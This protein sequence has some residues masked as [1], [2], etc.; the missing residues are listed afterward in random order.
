[1]KFYTELGVEDCIKRLKQET[2]PDKGFFS[3]LNPSKVVCQMSGHEFR[4]R[5]NFEGRGSRMVRFSGRLKLKDTGTEIEGH[6]YLSPMS[7]MPAALWNPFWFI[8]YGG[9]A[10]SAIFIF[11]FSVNEL[12]TV[13]WRWDVV[14]SLVG[15]LLIVGVFSLFGRA[16]Q[17]S[18]EQGRR[19]EEALLLNFLS[20]TLQAQEVEPLRDPPRRR[21]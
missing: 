13:G 12:F 1:M 16:I 14:G 2:A 19:E 18:S 17:L 10:C 6:L 15:W 9:L 20:S 21:Y 3:Y 11:V 7:R 5:P 8:W 4:L